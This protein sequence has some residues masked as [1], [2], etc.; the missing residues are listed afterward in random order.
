MVSGASGQLAQVF[1]THR[2]PGR[3]AVHR[4]DGRGDE[5]PGHEGNQSIKVGYADE[6]EQ[7]SKNW[8]HILTSG[9]SDRD[10]A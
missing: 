7:A 8:P 1:G 6:D 2:P 4:L 5:E 10:P 9:A 3:R